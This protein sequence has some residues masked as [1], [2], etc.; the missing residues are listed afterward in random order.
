MKE[1]PFC[2]Q[3]I[4]DWCWTCPHCGKKLPPKEIPGHAS[5]GKFEEETGF[6]A[7][8]EDEKMISD[9]GRMREDE[10]DSLEPDQP[11]SSTN[12]YWEE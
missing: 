9:K 3:E 10:D 12:H 7:S 6:L 1:C 4:D 11:L 5:K 8:S 2:H